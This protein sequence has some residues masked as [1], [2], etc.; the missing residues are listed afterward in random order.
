MF[1]C[2]IHSGDYAGTWH[3]LKAVKELGVAHAKASG[4]EVVA[5]MKQIPA[6]DDCFGPGRIWEDGR[7]IHASHLFQVKKPAKI[8]TPGA[9]YKHIA[10]T[11]IEE[12]FRPLTDG[13]CPLVRI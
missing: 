6:D 5:M 7:K 9:V 12:A 4:R 10:T 11:P 3:Y 2:S 1:P 8:T 13:G